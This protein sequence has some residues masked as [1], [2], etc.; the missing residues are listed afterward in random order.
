MA[1]AMSGEMLR[2]WLAPPPGTGLFTRLQ[3]LGQ[4]V[5]VVALFNVFP[6]PQQSGTAIHL[7]FC[8]TN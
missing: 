6:L 8:W 4:Y 5:L 7:R 3:L 1:I 2:G